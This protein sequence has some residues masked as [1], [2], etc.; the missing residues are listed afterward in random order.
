MDEQLKKE[1]EVLTVADKFRSLDNQY[2]RVGF[3]LQDAGIYFKMHHHE[4]KSPSDISM[5]GK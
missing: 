4:I 5:L 2:L 3:P 1:K